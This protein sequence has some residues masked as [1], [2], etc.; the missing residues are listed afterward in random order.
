MIVT[1]EIAATK[2]AL[3][4]TVISCDRL[5]AA[6]AKNTIAVANTA[7]AAIHSSIEVNFG[8]MYSLC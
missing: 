2:I 8:Y 3:P 1:I 4:P 7:I 5:R 6:R